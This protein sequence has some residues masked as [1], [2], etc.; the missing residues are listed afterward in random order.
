MAAL[1]ILRSVKLAM[2][3]TAFSTLVPLSVPAPFGLRLKD[4]VI[5]ED[6]A[7]WFPYASCTATEMPLRVAP[8]VLLGMAAV[9]ASWAAAATA[10]WKLE[11]ETLKLVV[12]IWSW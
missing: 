2:P 7:V 6:A 11:L 4:T 3:L 9:K 10:I 5:C 12:A 8:P 1:S